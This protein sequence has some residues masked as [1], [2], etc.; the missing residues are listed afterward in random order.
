MKYSIIIPAHNEESFLGHTLTSV[1]NQS[2]LPVEVIVVND[3]STDRT[4]EIVEEF[5]HKHSI[6]RLVNIDTPSTH[7]PGA[8]II[9]AFYKGFE[10]LNHD[11]DLI[12]KLDAD[13]I[14]PS[15]YF[16]KII[17][18]FK[19]NPNLGIAGG[20]I[21]IKSNNKWIY[22]NVS[23]KDHVRG[24]IKTYSKACFEKT[25]GPRRSI[26]WDTADEL[27]ALYNGFEIKVLPELKVKLL[28]PTGTVYK[29]IHGLKIGESFYKLDY[30]FLISLIAALKASWN[31]KNLKLFTDI[32]KGYWSSALKSENKIV[33]PK[34]GK[35]IRSYRMKGII[36]R[37]KF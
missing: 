28:K 35:F 14:L 24:A 25:G 23:K 8:K 19:N 11:W 30:G 4:A 37:L 12:A 26:G 18:S 20:R 5:I 21:Y 15:D 22:E 1:L 2:L 16:E 33:T 9:N 36:D 34:E 32:T 7:Q 10:A 27:L 6:F 3:G 31:N 17:Q 29:N 13:L